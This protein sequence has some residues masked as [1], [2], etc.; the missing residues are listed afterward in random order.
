MTHSYISDLFHRMII[1]SGSSACTFSLNTTSHVR[2]ICY[3][4]ALQL[5]FTPTIPT[6]TSTTIEQEENRQLVDFFRH[7]PASTLELSLIGKRGFHVNNQG[8]MDL[9]PVIDGD[10]FPKPL[11]DLRAEAPRKQVIAG[12]TE[13]ESLLFAAIR[14]PRGSLYK[15]VFRVVARDFDRRRVRLSDKCR[16]DI[17][18]TY[19]ASVD[20]MDRRRVAQTSILLASDVFIN[21][22]VWETAD[23]LVSVMVVG[24][25]S[26]SH[27]NLNLIAGQAG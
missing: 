24:Y 2:Q 23:E 3:K 7:I 22:G 1:M 4:F 27:F 13:Y 16:G 18:C 21:R 12:I 11:A 5:G 15:E 26:T 9:T 8:H 17:S 20:R 25:L 10:F 19:Y 14:P 6:T